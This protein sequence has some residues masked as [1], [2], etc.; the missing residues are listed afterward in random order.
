[1]EGGCAASW[2]TRAVPMRSSTTASAKRQV[3]MLT[4]AKRAAWGAGAAPAAP[5][6]QWRLHAEL[7]AIAMTKAGGAGAR[8]CAPGASAAG[9]ATTVIAE[10]PGPPRRERGRGGGWVRGGGVIGAGPP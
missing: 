2:G 4:A 1:M 6:V 7:V 9:E 5:K 10:P 3:P 8:G